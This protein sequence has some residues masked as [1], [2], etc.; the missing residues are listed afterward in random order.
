MFLAFLD[1]PTVSPRGRFTIPGLDPDQRY[2][3]AP[4]TV[5]TPDHGRADPT[6]Y[7]GDGTGVVLGGRALASAGLHLPGSFPERV[8]MYRVTAV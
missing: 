3:V 4:V 2:R 1:R 7:G 8:V 5:G 6:W